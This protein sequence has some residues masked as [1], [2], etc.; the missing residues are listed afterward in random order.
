MSDR[1]FFDTTILVYAVSGGDPRA[2][3]AENLLAT[4]GYISVQVL[5]E[6]AAVAIRPA[7]SVLDNAK[8]ASVEPMPAWQDALDAYLRAKGMAA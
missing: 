1:T 2:A 7:Y 3:V 4:G 5:N 6:F 8:L